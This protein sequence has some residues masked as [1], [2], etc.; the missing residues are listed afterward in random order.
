MPLSLVH[1]PDGSSVAFIDEETYMS[2]EERAGPVPLPV[3]R[4]P[5]PVGP[6][7]LPVGLQHCVFAAHRKV[8]GLYDTLLRRCLLTPILS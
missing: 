3:G 4:V 7:P 2:A 1:I 8:F 6:I 5:L